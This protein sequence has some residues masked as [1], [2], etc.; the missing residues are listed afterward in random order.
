[1]SYWE[2][3]SWLQWLSVLLLPPETGPLGHLMGRSVHIER[4]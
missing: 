3:L 1:M 4:A 2:C